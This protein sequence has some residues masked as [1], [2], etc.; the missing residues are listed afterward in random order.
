M[1]CGSNEYVSN[2]PSKF[3]GLGDT[4]KGLAAHSS[5]WCRWEIRN[6]S[7]A[8][9]RSSDSEHPAS[10]N[11]SGCRSR[12]TGSSRPRRA[13]S[14]PREGMHYTTID[15]RKVID[16]SAGLWCVN[17]GHGRQQIAAAVERQLMNLDFAPSFQM[18]HPLAFDFAERL[19]EIAPNGARSHLLHQFGLGIGRYRAEDRA[20]LSS[21]RRP[22]DPH[23]AD[24]PRARL[25]RR[26]LRR[27]VGR[28]HGQQPPRVRDP[29]SGRRSYPPHPR[30]RPQRFLEGQPEHGAELADDLER[31]VALHGADTIAAVIVEPV[32][33][34]TAVLPPPKSYLQRLRAAMRQ[35]RHPPDLRRSHHRLRPARRAVRRRNISASRRT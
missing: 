6:R 22:T 18:G 1:C 24:R 11:R 28:R 8:H 27:H 31:L 4:R 33:G 2:D 26:R 29:S 17:A 15:G 23:A 32:P 3:N 12:P 16:G 19:A 9:D 30:S 25:S 5:T 34:S 10:S 21:R 35:A 20:G 7:D 13:C 14:P